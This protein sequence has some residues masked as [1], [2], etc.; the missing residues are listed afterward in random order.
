[1]FDAFGII[2]IYICRKFFY[3]TPYM[4]K[5]KMSGTHGYVTSPGA[6]YFDPISRSQ[7]RVLV[8][9]RGLG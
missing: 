8:I 6:C 7:P 5:T 4:V 1:M 2:Y 9:A 3:L